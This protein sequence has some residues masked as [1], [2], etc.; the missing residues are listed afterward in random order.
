[1]PHDGST[2][3][4]QDRFRGFRR[5]H[6]SVVAEF[7]WDVFVP[8]EDLSHRLTTDYLVSEGE[9]VS[10]GGRTWIVENVEIDEA[11]EGANGKIDVVPAAEPT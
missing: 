1:M 8:G 5:V 11:I 7:V 4:E 2:R 3:F 10:L 6:S 9:Q